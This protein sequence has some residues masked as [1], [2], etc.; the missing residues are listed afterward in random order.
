MTGNKTTF[1]NFIQENR[2]EIPIIQRDYAQG[3]LGKE[4]LRASFLKN[5][6]DALDDKLQNG[7]KVLKLD[8]VYGTIEQGRLQPLDG[9]QR[10]TTLWLLHWYIALRAG[11]LREVIVSQEESQKPKVSEVLS[12]FTYETRISSREFCEHLCDENNFQ[13]YTCADGSYSDGCTSISIVDFITT[14]TWFYSVW[15]YDPTIQSMLRMLGGTKINN[16][17][18]EDIIDGIEEL[19]KETDIDTFET[20]WQKLTCNSPI[21]F[22]YL[23]LKEFG[24]SDDLYIKMNARGKQLTM[25]ENFKADLIGYI[26]EMAESEQD[27]CEWKNL[28]NA[29]NGIP[30][31]MDTTWTDL[32][33]MNKSESKKIDE[34]YFAFLNRYI[35]NSLISSGSSANEIEANK[36]FIYLYGNKG[37]DTA[38]QYTGF[39]IYKIPALETILKKLR[40]ALENFHTF[41]SKMAGQKLEEIQKLFF[42]SWDNQNNFRFVPEYKEDSITFL[43]QSQRVIFHA[44]CKYFEQGEYEE[45][46]FKRWMRVVWNLVENGSINSIESMIGSLRLI[47]ELSL[48]SHDIYD[49]LAK[50][51]PIK[52]ESASEQQKEEREK[53]KKIIEDASWEEK[54]IKAEKYAFFKGTIRF[55]FRDENNECNWSDFDKKWENARNFFQDNNPYEKGYELLRYFISLFT[56]WSLFWGMTFDNENNSWK[57]VLVN[58]KW[59]KPIHELLTSDRIEVT[60]G[61]KS[62]LEGLDVKYEEQQKKVQEDLVTTSLLEHIEKGCH[63]NWRYDNYV[64]YP[65]NVKADWKKYIIANT[66]NESLPLLYGGKMSDDNKQSGKIYTDQKIDGCN[67]FWGRNIK[68]EYVKEGISYTFH[69]Q[70][71]NWIDMYDGDIR[72]ID[73]ENSS[74]YEKLKIDASKINSENLTGELERCIND[75]IESQKQLQT[76]IECNATP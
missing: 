55:L 76:N 9:Q 22:Y 44:V 42:P 33:W 40:T 59:S 12:N 70:S 1:W 14:Q 51:E 29:K 47:D 2:I 61:Y 48:H 54:I 46:S 69:W 6:K 4:Y 17:K 7:E 62:P 45:K 63:L 73:K 49:F 25:L 28:L 74:A 41:T 16:K 5:L 43:T 56:D 36:T 72:L 35:L 68:F 8:F 18:G 32:F 3:R 15:K 11:K 31:K 65:Y 57:Y 34:I 38:L 10:L 60:E 23:P 75:Y 37:N 50:D 66:R 27:N 64:L 30:I 52:S 39:E 71:W 19:F 24:L 21:V 26:Q 67:F 13:S 20:Y 53:A 58:K